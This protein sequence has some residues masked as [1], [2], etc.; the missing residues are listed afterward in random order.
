MQSSNEET[1]FELEYN[2]KIEY[3][4]EMRGRFLMGIDL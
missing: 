1:D 3:L 4:W 2:T